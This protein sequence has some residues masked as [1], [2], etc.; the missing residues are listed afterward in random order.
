MPAQNQEL[1]IA[2][3][4]IPPSPSRRLGRG[5]EALVPAS[6]KNKSITEVDID[7]I[8]TN[9]LQP[10]Q[11]F[12]DEQ[13]NELAHSI[14]EHGIIQPLLVKREGQQYTLIAGERRLQAAKRANLPRVPVIVRDVTN[15][16]LLELAIIENI[17]RTDLNAL[18]EAIAYQQLI[19]EFNLSQVQVARRLGKSHSTVSNTLRLLHLPQEIKKALME[20]IISEGH[21]RAL[22][23]AESP[24]QL[25]SLFKQVVEK[26]LSVRETERLVREKNGIFVNRNQDN[27]QGKQQVSLP[28]ALQSYEKQFKQKSGLPTKISLSKRG[29]KV[30][31]SF[32]TVDEL[33]KFM[34]TYL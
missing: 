22:L 1:P 13:L 34:G 30:T 19:D 21:A 9:P 33:E 32:K 24:K 16:E 14:K 3:E 15:K 4:K 20:G 18:E 31:I 28:K 10:R 29:G 5:L 25:L 11:F 17:Q 8:N 26:K 7:T 6:E 2:D 23:G 12:S 27:T